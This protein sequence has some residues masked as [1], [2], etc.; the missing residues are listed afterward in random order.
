MLLFIDGTVK[1]WDL[2]TNTQIQKLNHK[3]AVKKVCYCEYTR[4]AFAAS[5]SEVTLWDV[6]QNPAA[7]NHT[8]RYALCIFI[9]LFG[10]QCFT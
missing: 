9:V 10:K 7:C 5:A 1:I 8:F 3:E 2:M 6:R 4:R